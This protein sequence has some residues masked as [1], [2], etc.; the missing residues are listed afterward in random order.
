MLLI[1]A[2]SNC[3]LQNYKKE[4]N[5]ERKSLFLYCHDSI[6]REFSRFSSGCSFGFSTMLRMHQ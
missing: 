5:R 4:R 3:A 2:V 1:I 6:F